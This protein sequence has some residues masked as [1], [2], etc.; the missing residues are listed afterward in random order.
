MFFKKIHY[1][2]IQKLKKIT[3][4]IKYDQFNEILTFWIGGADIFLELG[5]IE[6]CLNILFHKKINGYI[7]HSNFLILFPKNTILKPNQLYHLL[8]ICNIRIIF[9]ANNQLKCLLY[10]LNFFFLIIKLGLLYLDNRYQLQNIILM[11]KAICSTIIWNFGSKSLMFYW[12][13]KT[14]LRYDFILH[15]EN[16]INKKSSFR[17]SII[18]VYIIYMYLNIRFFFM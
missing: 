8:I 13:C 12:F 16:L 5:F 2:L 18:F 14:K 3:F 17:C 10:T 11:T 1:F 15:N 9:K 7:N 6:N 4:F